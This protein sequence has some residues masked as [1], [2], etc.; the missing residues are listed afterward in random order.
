MLLLFLARFVLRKNWHAFMSVLCFNVFWQIMRS[1]PPK[2][3]NRRFIKRQQYRK[4]YSYVLCWLIFSA[5]HNMRIYYINSII[6]HQI[7]STNNQTNPWCIIIWIYLTL[8]AII[9]YTYTH[10]RWDYSR[11]CTKH[12]TKNTIIILYYFEK[13]KL[14][15][16]AIYST[17]L[18]HN[19]SIL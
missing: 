10:I 6:I 12:K 1:T 3:K 16:S 19:T 15:S 8:W 18:P 4:I 14:L 13:Q 9:T 17:I 2:N 5:N 11:V 7:L